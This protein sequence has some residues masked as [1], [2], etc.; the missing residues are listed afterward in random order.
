MRSAIHGSITHHIRSAQRSRPQRRSGKVAQH[1]QQGVWH[2]SNR[3]EKRRHVAD[4]RD[5]AI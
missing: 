5:E 4:W 2:A 1:Q 3:D